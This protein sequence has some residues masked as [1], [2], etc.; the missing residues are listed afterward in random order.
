MLLQELLEGHPSIDLHYDLVDCQISICSPHVPQ[1]FTD[2][3]DYL[4]RDHFVKGI[5]EHEEVGIS[6]DD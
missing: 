3:F 6:I 5:L 1:L 2:E 4:T